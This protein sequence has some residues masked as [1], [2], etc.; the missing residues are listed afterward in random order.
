MATKIDIRNREK[1]YF[2]SLHTSTSRNYFERM[3]PAKAHEMQ[4]SK[5]FARDYWDGDR[6]FGYGGYK[7]DGRWKSLAEKLINDYHLTNTSKLLDLGCGKGFLLFEIRS[8][9]PEIEIVGLDISKYAIE[10]S[11]EEIRKD[12]KIHDI[13]NTLDFTYKEFDLVISLMTIHN[14]ELP[15]LEFC[16]SEI[17]RVA[18]DSYITTESYRNEAELSN[19]Q[20]WALTCE[21]FFSPR[22]WQHI[23]DR[24]GYCGDFELLYF[25]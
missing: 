5:L 24:S 19:L 3:S 11:K 15:E 13:R 7:Y 10:N 16:L 22:E 1:T 4:I 14:L 9:L 18:K 25:E 23:F 2:K 12:L 20:C 6:R 8:L 17:S 21:S